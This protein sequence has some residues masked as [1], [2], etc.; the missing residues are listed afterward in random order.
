M[1]RLQLAVD[2]LSLEEALDFL[3][4]ASAYIDI[5]EV[6]TP[7]LYRSGLKAVRRIREA[8]PGLYIL[9]DGKIMDAGAYESR[10]QFEA[11]ADCVSVLGVTDDAT[12]R[13]CVKEAAKFGKEVSADT[14]CIPNLAERIGQL[15]DMGVDYISVH[16][17]VDQQAR[18]RTPLDDLKEIKSCAERAGISVAGGIRLDTVEQYLALEPDVIIVGGGIL[19]QQDPKAAARAMR[20]KMQQFQR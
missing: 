3:G 13:E 18:G 12:I 9:C 4:E 1:V 19:G 6:G 17:G 16:T 8:F 10:E 14:I 11:G 7:L 5:V 20:E 2:T 15:E